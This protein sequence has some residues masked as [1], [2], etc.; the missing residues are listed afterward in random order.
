MPRIVAARLLFQSGGLE[1]GEDMA[2]LDFGQRHGF[3][4]RAGHHDIGR[5][6]LRRQAGEREV[7][8]FD[9]VALRQHDR[10]F[11]HVLEFA[12]VAGPAIVPHAIEGLRRESAQTTARFRIEPVQEV[13]G[14]FNHIFGAFAQRRH[15]DLEDPQAKIEV[16]PELPFGDGLL[17]VAIGGRHGAH[18]D[19]DLLIAAHSFERMPFQD[20]EEFGLDRRTHFA[21]LVEHQGAQVRGFELAD[22]PFRGA[23]ERTA[24]VPEQLAF[25]AASR[26]AR[27]S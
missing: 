5:F 17:Q 4:G 8:G 2:F 27:R 15:E 25:Q 13:D 9:G 14:Q 16:A 23:G 1:R 12:Y 7:V 21:D 24:L 10:A 11:H 6:P 19:A 3:V 20:A 22:L 26:S 18:I